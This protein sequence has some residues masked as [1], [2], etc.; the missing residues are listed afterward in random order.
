MI[1]VVPEN[2]QTGRRRRA[3]LAEGD[4]DLPPGVGLRRDDFAGVAIQMHGNALSA[5]HAAVNPEAQRV[6]PAEID[7]RLMAELQAVPALR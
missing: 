5:A 1:G 2:D 6:I 7:G 4:V 3:Q